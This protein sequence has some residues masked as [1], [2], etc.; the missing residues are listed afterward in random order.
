LDRF[1]AE[2]SKTKNILYI[3]TYDFTEKRIKKLFSDL[4]DRRVEIKLIME[5]KK[6]QQFVD[7][8]KQVQNQ[9]S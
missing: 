3:Q 7:T 5:N 6:Y 4:L 2:V 1:S 9:F 8:F